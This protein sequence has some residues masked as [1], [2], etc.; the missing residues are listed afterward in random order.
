MSSIGV[1]EWKAPSRMAID[2]SDNIYI[3]RGN[4][5]IAYSIKGTKQKYDVPIDKTDDW[6]LGPNFQVFNPSKSMSHEYST[7]SYG[8]R[9]P[10]KP[11]EFLFHEIKC[12]QNRGPSLDFNT[13]TKTYS[14]TLFWNDRVSVS[15][16]QGRFLYKVT[17]TPIFLKVF[18]FP[19]PFLGILLILA[20]A[21]WIRVKI[22]SAKQMKTNMSVHSDAPEGGA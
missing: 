7:C 1:P 15:D 12:D 9:K 20:A 11:G 6:S 3:N 4:T 2:V 21:Y 19:V 22:D 8:N 10:V 16:D 18:A 17:I 5:V 14:L 13:S